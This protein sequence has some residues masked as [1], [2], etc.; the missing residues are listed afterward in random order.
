MYQIV[1]ALIF[2]IKLHKNPINLLIVF[3]NFQLYLLV[4]IYL[5]IHESKQKFCGFRKNFNR[6]GGQVQTHRGMQ[7]NRFKIIA[8][9]NGRLESTDHGIQFNINLH[10]QRN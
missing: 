2:A 1:L 10:K 3:R 8:R 9:K 5:H 6:A 7:K 4:K